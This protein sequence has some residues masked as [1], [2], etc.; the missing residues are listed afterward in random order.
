LGLTV[1]GGVRVQQNQSIAVLILISNSAIISRMF[2]N[3]F[4]STFGF[5]L[6]TAF[7]IENP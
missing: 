7:N 2:S 4:G 3:F 1:A 5:S 6:E